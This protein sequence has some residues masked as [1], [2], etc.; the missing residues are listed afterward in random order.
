MD[1]KETTISPIAKEPNN[2]QPVFSS[3]AESDKKETTE[4]E[5]VESSPYGF[6]D[7]AQ[8]SKVRALVKKS[9]KEILKE[10][11]V[12][13]YI[14]HGK[15]LI[16]H[17]VEVAYEDNYVLIALLKKIV[18]DK[19]GIEMNFNLTKEQRHEIVGRM[20]IMLDYKKS[21]AGLDVSSVE[22]TRESL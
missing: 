2:I 8:Q 10:S 12:K 13:A 4:A 19:T 1:E 6:L 7:P 16:E 5:L 3:E 9:Y 11:L 17:A 14:A 18:P 22:T 15:H 21:V 20:K